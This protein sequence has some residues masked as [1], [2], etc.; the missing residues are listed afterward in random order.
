MIYCKE[1]LIYIQNVCQSIRW[2][3]FLWTESSAT[4]TQLKTGSENFTGLH[5]DHRSSVQCLSLVFL[6]RSGSCCPPCCCGHR[7]RSSS[8]SAACGLCGAGRSSGPRSPPGS[9]AQSPGSARSPPS[10]SAGSLASRPGT[11]HWPGG[12]RRT[13]SKH[14]YKGLIYLTGNLGAS[15]TV[16]IIT[17]HHPLPAL[18][19]VHGGLQ[20]QQQV[21]ESGFAGS[22]QVGI[23]AAALLPQVQLAGFGQGVTDPV[24]LRNQLLADSQRVTALPGGRG[25]GGQTGEVTSFTA[26]LTG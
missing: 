11:H 2:I 22:R 21:R 12:L 3:F 15:L 1:H 18:T 20:A 19:T 5:S 14:E 25:R 7:V 13:V 4:L 26:D 8:G 10:A 23:Q 6:Q 9:A 24:V 16:L 17:I